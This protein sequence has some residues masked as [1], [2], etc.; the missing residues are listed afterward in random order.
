M[1]SFREQRERM[2]A[3]AEVG[4]REDV[5]QRQSR[6]RARMLWMPPPG[7][8]ASGLAGACISSSVSL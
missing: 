5:E 1:A 4:C 7:A 3:E 2:G 8:G 6:A